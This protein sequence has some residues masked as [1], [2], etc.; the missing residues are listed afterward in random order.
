MLTI[1]SKLIL[2]KH[3]LRAMPTYFLMLLEFTA[4]GYR[5]LEAVCRR[6]LWGYSVGGQSKAPLVAWEKICQP[7]SEGGL[8][9][10]EFRTQA[11]IF[12]LRFV[13][14]ILD[15]HQADWVYMVKAEIKAGLRKGR[16]KKELKHWSVAEYVLLRPP[17]HFTSKIVRCL[18]KS[19]D[20]IYPKLCL[21][22]TTGEITGTLTILKAYCLFR[23][24]EQFLEEEY[25]RLRI[26][27][28][29]RRVYT[30]ADMRKDGEWI[31]EEDFAR[32]IWSARHIDRPVF[33]AFHDF[34]TIFIGVTELPLDEME[35]WDWTGINKNGLEWSLPNRCWKEL[36]KLPYIDQSHLNRRWGCT[37]TGQEWSKLWGCLWAPGAH[38][39]TKFVIWR[40]LQHGFFT[41]VR[42]AIWKVCEALCPICGQTGETI[43]HLF[44]ECE[45]VKQRW[46][47]AIRLLRATSMSLGRVN[48][49]FQIIEAAVKRHPQNPSILILLEEM[50]CSAWCGTKYGRVSRCQAETAV[51]D[52]LSPVCNQNEGFGGSYDG[53]NAA[54]ITERVSRNVGTLC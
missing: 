43:A 36:V 10:T 52:S 33:Q 4:E 41:N 2:I 17:A 8:G 21:D 42:G 13:A 48:S 29:A 15:K 49:A 45:E 51:T 35:G 39:R 50:V 54:G 12:K 1:P 24:P 6:F 28:Q 40:L 23:G 14:R 19:W 37:L 25:R 38:A 5:E 7:K 30:V 11:M 44:F 22:P 27:D 18:L 47:K 9:L 3:I 31:A 26:W 34:V 53:A 46:V 16:F 20:L 32:R